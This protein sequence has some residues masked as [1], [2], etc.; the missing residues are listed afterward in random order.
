[1][2]VKNNNAAVL[3]FAFIGFLI[4]F[5]EWKVKYLILRIGNSQDIGISITGK[6]SWLVKPSIVFNLVLVCVRPPRFQSNWLD[7]FYFNWLVV[8]LQKQV[9]YL[10]DS[11]G[12]IGW[13]KLVVKLFDCCD[14]L[15]FLVFESHVKTA[16]NFA[17]CQRSVSMWRNAKWVVF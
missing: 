14:W 11:D 2:T 17:T 5:K 6:S 16:A 15:Q 3:V 13:L 7:W 8:G 4:G 12:S 10:L 9:N 1:M